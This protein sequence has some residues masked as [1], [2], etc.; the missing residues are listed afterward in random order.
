MVLTLTGEDGRPS[1]AT[2]E[3]NMKRAEEAILGNQ[4]VTG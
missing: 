1:A 2:N 3:Q 4:S